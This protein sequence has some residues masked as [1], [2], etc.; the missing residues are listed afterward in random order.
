M[1][2]NLTGMLYKENGKRNT[3]KWIRKKLLMNKYKKKYSKN[4]LKGYV[5][6]SNFLNNFEQPF[7]IFLNNF[8]II[9]EYFLNNFKHLFRIFFEY[10][11]V[12]V[13]TAIVIS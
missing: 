7:Q 6:K 9:F 11:S 12:F 4:I 13:Q 3:Y 10:F 5:M 8:E 1:R 2:F